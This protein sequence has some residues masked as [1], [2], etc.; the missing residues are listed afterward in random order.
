MGD[1]VNESRV[2]VAM[3]RIYQA[4]GNPDQAV[5]VLEQALKIQR[6]VGVRPDEGST[7]NV[8]GLAYGSQDNLPKAT[9]T[10]QQAIV[11]H[12]ET[13]D[14][15]AEA[16]A[17]ANMGEVLAATQPEVAIVF[18]KQSVNV[19]EGI[20]GGLGTLPQDLQQSYTDS[21]ADD[22]RAL[23]DLLL[24]QGRIPE[25][26]QVL[27][28]LKLEELREFTNTRAT[29]TGT[30]LAYTDQEEP[31]VEE[32][33]S[34]MAFGQTLYACQQTNC[35]DLSRLMAQQD[36]L[37]AAY[38]DEVQKF[39]A[40]VQQRSSTDR[41]LFQDPDNLNGEAQALLAANPNSVLIY[42]FVTDDKLW[43]LWAAGSAVGSVEVPVKQ[44]E[45]SQTV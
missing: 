18:Y 1:V 34:L 20:R 40:T 5:A 27:D 19:R 17:L 22:Y 7:L 36:R 3:G 30:D 24:E 41:L 13:G 29:W 8:L 33:T 25:A 12:Q 43:L 2:L 28:L 26:Q 44:G 45:L 35:A 15:A 38:N 10:L 39:E 6:E 11:I 21:V 42:P 37:I 14:L 23:A 4:Q 16:E 9:A 31:I 32:H